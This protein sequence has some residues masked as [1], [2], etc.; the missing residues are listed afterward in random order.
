MFIHLALFVYDTCMYAIDHK[1]SFAIS[2]QWRCGVRAG[3]IKINE[4][5][6]SRSTSPVDLDGLSP[7]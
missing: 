4:E 1:E 3:T 7:I 6:L 5:K 2:A